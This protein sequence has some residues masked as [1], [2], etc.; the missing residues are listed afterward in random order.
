MQVGLETTF[1][2]VFKTVFFKNMYLFSLQSL[3]AELYS[4]G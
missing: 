1:S 4:F 2:F 3:L